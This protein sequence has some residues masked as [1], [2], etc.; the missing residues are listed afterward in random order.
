MSS[1]PR[2]GLWIERPMQRDPEERRMTPPQ[3]VSR[4]EWLVARK[5]L[6]VKKKELTRQRDA[7]NVEHRMLP[8]V[9][10]VEDYVFEGPQGQAS[11][12]DLFDGRRQLIV[13]HFMFGPSWDEGC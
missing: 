2:A 9:E 3:A 7:L 6:L 10:I 13:G 1:R 11:L 5:E 8:M 4:H 12:L